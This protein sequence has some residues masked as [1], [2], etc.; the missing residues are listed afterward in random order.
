MAL[1]S[2]QLQERQQRRENAQPEFRKIMALEEIA[3]ALTDIR[4]ELIQ[5]RMAIPRPTGFQSRS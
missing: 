2:K 5:L 4:G 3:D 1:S